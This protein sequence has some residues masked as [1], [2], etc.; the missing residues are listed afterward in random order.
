VIAEQQRMPFIVGPWRRVKRSDA[1]AR[2][3]ADRHY[4]RQT[5][6]AV[7]FMPAGRV[8]VL[9]THCGRA[10]WGVV[11]NLDPAGELRWRCSI[12][13]NEGAGLSSE[14]IRE[15]TTLTHVRW[16]RRYGALPPV[17]LTTEIDAA[18]VRHKRDPGRCFFRAGWRYVRTTNGAAKG[19]ADLVVLEAPEHE[20]MEAQS[21]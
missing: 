14:L 16:R 6:G 1:R 17:A 5:V 8:F 9:L 2:A 3:L 12:F 11:E 21:T 19:R 4:S 15:A 18:S 20:R 13:R 10:V 7:D